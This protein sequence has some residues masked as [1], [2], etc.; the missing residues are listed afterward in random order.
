VKFGHVYLISRNDFLFSVIV[1]KQNMKE[2]KQMIY[3]HENDRKENHHLIFK[4]QNKDL[5]EWW[6]II[7][8]SPS[9]KVKFCKLKTICRISFRSLVEEGINT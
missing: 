6:E 8:S 9:E 4:F 5:L 1:D 3:K 7:R 2:D